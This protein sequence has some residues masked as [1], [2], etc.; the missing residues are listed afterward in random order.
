MGK[1]EEFIR[2]IEPLNHLFYH[3]NVTWCGKTGRVHIQTNP[4]DGHY[5]SILFHSEEDGTARL[6]FSLSYPELFMT[7][8]N[9]PGH[10]PGNLI[11]SGEYLFR[12]LGIPCPPSCHD[13]R[14]DVYAWSVAI[15]DNLPKIQGA[16]SEDRIRKTAHSLRA[17]SGNNEETVRNVLQYTHSL[18]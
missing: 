6:Y 2:A 15:R 4:V 14:K 18:G 13:P 10:S 1:I 8:K 17:T 16:L 5:W 12:L 3:D 7:S 9:E 11:F